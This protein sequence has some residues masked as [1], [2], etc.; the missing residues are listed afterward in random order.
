[1]KLQHILA[2]VILSAVTTFAIIK[3]MPSQSTTVAHETAYDRVMRTGVLRCGYADWPPYVLIKDA[4]TGKLSGIAP[5]ITEA[6]AQKLHLKVEWTENT[7]WG[8]FVESLRDRRIDMMCAFSWR[9][10]DR[11]RYLAYTMPV[12]YSAVFPYVAVDDHRFD[13]DLSLINSP[14]IRISAMDGETS[15]EIAKQYFPKATPV[16]VPQLGQITDILMN[17][18]THKA[19]VVFNEPS[20]VNDYIKANPNSLRRAQEEPFQ[21]YPSV[22]A[23]DIH[24]MQLREMVDSALTELLNQGGIDQIL[25]KYNDDPKVFLRVAKPYR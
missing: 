21:T 19:D 8:S 24:E 4:T 20:F 16:S 9:N 13:K 18:A 10:G 22:F 23:M 17:V 15:D 2:T 5:D 12:F 25:S 11:G 14:A 3:Y 6:V 7:G 1:M